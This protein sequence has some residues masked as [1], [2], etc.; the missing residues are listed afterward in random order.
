MRRIVPALAILI[1]ASGA[2][3]AQSTQP[4]DNLADGR[5]GRI[6]FQSLTPSGYFHLARGP[7]E[8]TATI[9]GTLQIP[10]GSGR[11]PAMVIS[12]GSGGI[13]D[14]R[15]HR[16]AGQ[17]NKLG[18]ASFVVDSF[19]P[20]GIHDTA[21]NQSQ[22]S[23]AANVADALAALRLL[24]THPRIDVARIGI[25]GFSKGGQVV[26]Y[27]ALEPFRRAVIRD[28]THFAAHVAL[29]P[30]CNDWYQS[31]LLDGAPLL[32][33]LGGLDDYTPPAPCQSYADWFRGKSPDVTVIVYPNAYHGFDTNRN[34]A[35]INDLVTGRNCDMAIDLD[36]FTVKIRTSGE[37][38]TKDAASYARKCLSRGATMGGDG[39]ARRRAP[40]DIEG[41]LKRVFRL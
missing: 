3:R 31:E 29:Y 10:E 8:Q 12:H 9:W 27:T 41:F 36:R 33:L 6:Y 19:G 20:R 13:T 28:N 5:A 16:W 34:R 24:A 38:I 2:A 4:V 7:V 17:L 22:L 40:Q 21:S 32:M 25:M 15:E 39:E 14:D 11:L 35:F 26:L 30:Y 1:V 37:D 23:T 18:L